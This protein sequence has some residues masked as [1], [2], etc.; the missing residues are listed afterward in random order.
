MNELDEYLCQKW[1]EED[2]ELY[3]F[4]FILSLIYNS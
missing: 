4:V 2:N 3:N 1:R